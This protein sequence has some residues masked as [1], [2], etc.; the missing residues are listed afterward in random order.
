MTTPIDQQWITMDHS[1]ANIAPASEPTIELTINT[2]PKDEKTEEG[3]KCTCKNTSKEDAMSDDEADIPVRDSRSRDRRRVPRRYS[4]SP[5][6]VRL[7]QRYRSPVRDE[8]TI[9]KSSASL[10]EKAGDYDGVADM[11]YP[12]RT[13]VYLTTYPFTTRDVKKW[14]WLLGNGVE[15]QWATESLSRSAIHAGD[16]GNTGYPI[17]SDIPRRSRSPYYDPLNS[18]PVPNIFL[19][20]ALDKNVVPEDAEGVK[21]MVI[22]QDKQTPKQSKLVVAESRKAAGIVIYYEAISGNSVTFVGA[23]TT[24]VER[25]ARMKVKKVASLEEATEV[26]KDGFLG[27]VC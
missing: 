3:K 23:T 18:A 5:S 19:S 24:A 12:A 21:Y 20:R 16:D 15:E 8:L 22:V 7:R 6:P 27:L 17:I 14:G 4:L 11:P 26:E 13:S 2:K 9:L 25:G 10:L 1:D